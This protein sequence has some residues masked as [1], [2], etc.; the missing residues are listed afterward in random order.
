MREQFD[1]YKD[2]LFPYATGE[3]PYEEFA[4]R[5]LRRSRGEPEDFGPDGWE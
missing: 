2:L 1:Q 4:G 5:A 3:M